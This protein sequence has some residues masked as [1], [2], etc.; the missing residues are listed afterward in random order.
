MILSNT[1][2]AHYRTQVSQLLTRWQRDAP[3]IPP[4]TIAFAL[5]AAAHTAQRNAPTTELIW[6][7]PTTTE[8]TLR[9]S[10]QALLQVIQAAQKELLLVSFTVYPIPAVTQALLDA[11]KRG[12]TLTICLEA[13]QSGAGKINYDTIQSLGQEITSH[14]QIVIWPRHKRIISASGQIGTL[15]AKCAVADST[16]LFIS[17][18]NLTD[19][20]MSRNIELGVLIEGGQLPAQVRAQFEGLILIQKKILQPFS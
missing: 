4:S 18:A 6:T 17:S 2:Q 10:E 13:P 5:K 3:T 8:I 11:I 20:A 7:G 16:H 15:H 12:V 1:P 14:A 19:Y 9:Q